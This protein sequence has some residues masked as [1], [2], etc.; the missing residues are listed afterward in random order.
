MTPIEASL[1]YGSAGDYRTLTDCAKALELPYITLY[2]RL[3]VLPPEEHP[4]RYAVKAGGHWTFNVDAAIAWCQRHEA[5]W[6]ERQ[7]ARTTK[8]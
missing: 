3:S 8:K 6:A 5:Y 7:A 1:R 2:A 4:E